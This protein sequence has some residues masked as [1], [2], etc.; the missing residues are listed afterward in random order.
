MTYQTQRTLR[1][2]LLEDGAAAARVRQNLCGAG[3]AVAL[4]RVDTRAAFE[5]ALREFTPDVVI[6]DAGLAQVEPA[7]ALEL[8]RAR[9]P[10]LPVVFVESEHRHGTARELFRAGAA[11]YVACDGLWRIGA[12]VRSALA[13]AAAARERQLAAAAGEHLRLMALRFTQVAA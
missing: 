2:L 6:A 4:L 3:L 13:R 8:A 12:A 9:S 1:I 7:L 10:N 11:D 5:R